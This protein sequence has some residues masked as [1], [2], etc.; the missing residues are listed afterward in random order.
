MFKSSIL[1][2][3]CVFQVLDIY[4][5][6]EICYVFFRKGVW[7]KKVLKTKALFVELL[8]ALIIIIAAGC[9]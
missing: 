3:K 9:L 8:N 7:I 4:M 5:Y 2:R 6:L 1:V